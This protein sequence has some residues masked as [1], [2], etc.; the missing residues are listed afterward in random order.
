MPL[1]CIAAKFELRVRLRGSAS[2]ASST[3]Q[4]AKL[5]CNYSKDIVAA[6]ASLTSYFISVTTSRPGYQIASINIMENY[7]LK[8]MT[9]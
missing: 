1:C 9:G 7:G 3:N 8:E 2:V 6:K 4:V 5:F